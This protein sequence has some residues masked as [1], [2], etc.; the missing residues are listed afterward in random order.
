MQSGPVGG[1]VR[2]G[3]CVGVGSCGC[4]SAGAVTPSPLPIHRPVDAA[5]AA[6]VSSDD[7]SRRHDFGG[8]RMLPLRIFFLGRLGLSTVPDGRGA[9]VSG[10][11]VHVWLRA[12]LQGR[13]LRRGVLTTMA[14]SI[15]STFLKT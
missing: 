3:V 9:L 11:Q 10:E 4:G 7:G 12:Q 6:T 5:D 13:G 1:V 2:V 8:F 15:A 14:S